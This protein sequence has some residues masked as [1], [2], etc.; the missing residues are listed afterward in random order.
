MSIDEKAFDSATTEWFRIICKDK[1]TF[2]DGLRQFL[3]AYLAAKLSSDL[4]RNQ[5]IFDMGVEHA[6]K[7][8]QPVDRLAHAER[9]MDAMHHDLD[10]AVYSIWGCEAEH[11][12]PATELDY[13]EY[14]RRWGVGRKGEIAS[15]PERESV[16]RHPD[17]IDYIDGWPGNICAERHD[18]SKKWVLHYLTDEQAEKCKHALSDHPIADEWVRSSEWQGNPKAKTEGENHE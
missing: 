2:T 17:D 14:K 1:G 16:C 12:R 9:V 10:N 7:A 4:Q 13:Q 8:G 18:V 6:K 11:H 3:E 15:F 5:D